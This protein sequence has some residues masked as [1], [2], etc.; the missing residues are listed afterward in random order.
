[1]LQHLGF[2]WTCLHNANMQ[3][4]CVGDDGLSNV[5]LSGV[6]KSGLAGNGICEVGE[7]RSGAN[8]GA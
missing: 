6:V 3:E 5:T 2:W 7:L 4:G 1:M 8:T